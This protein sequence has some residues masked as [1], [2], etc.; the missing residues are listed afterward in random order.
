MRR[1]L[2]PGHSQVAQC[3]VLPGAMGIGAGAAAAVAGRVAAV[4]V[5]A[6][7]V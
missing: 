7:A 4:A 1:R 5:A 3:R 2:E 6:A